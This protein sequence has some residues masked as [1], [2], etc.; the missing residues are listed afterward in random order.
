MTIWKPYRRCVKCRNLDGNGFAICMMISKLCFTRS[1]L[2]IHQDQRVYQNPNEYMGRAGQGRAE[3]KVMKHGDRGFIDP[4]T[5]CLQ[6]FLYCSL[7]V[8]GSNP[9]M[10]VAATTAGDQQLQQTANV[11][12]KEKENETSITSNDK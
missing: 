9:T 8:N 4:S 1:F 5:I 10:A 12:E 2:A 3:K 7:G 6:W 11:S